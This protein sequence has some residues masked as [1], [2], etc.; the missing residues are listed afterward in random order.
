M[1]DALLAQGAE[2]ILLACTELSLLT[3][4]RELVLNRPVYDSAQ[5]VAERVVELAGASVRAVALG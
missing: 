2:L 4:V 3:G 1:A 5:L